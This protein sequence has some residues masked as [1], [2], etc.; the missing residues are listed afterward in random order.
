[1]AVIESVVGRD[2]RDSDWM[3]ASGVGQQVID[4]KHTR[5]AMINTTV[6]QICCAAVLAID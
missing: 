3:A 5:D 6:N 4:A 1:M 2:A